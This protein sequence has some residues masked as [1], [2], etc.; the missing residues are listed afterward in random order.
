M[1]KLPFG[2]GLGF[3]PLS[4]TGATEGGRGGSGVQSPW[5][6]QNS[7]PAHFAVI[8]TRDFPVKV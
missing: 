3:S 6:N 1:C 8:R 7:A 4:V 5:F 2:V